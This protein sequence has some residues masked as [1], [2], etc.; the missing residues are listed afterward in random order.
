MNGCCRWWRRSRDKGQKP[1]ELAASVP[2]DW[3]QRQ[4]RA[5]WAFPALLWRHDWWLAAFCAHPCGYRDFLLAPSTLNLQHESKQWD[6][7]TLHVQKSCTVW[8]GAIWWDIRALYLFSKTFYTERMVYWLK[9][10]C[11][12][13]SRSF[14]FAVLNGIFYC[15]I[16]LDWKINQNLHIWKLNEKTCFSAVSEISYRCAHINTHRVNTTSS[17]S[18]PEFCSYAESLL[19]HSKKASLT[20]LQR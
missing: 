13:R 7:Y 2:W 18:T 15:L 17:Y 1:T 8:N 14:A 3:R 19:T 12:I 6:I 10:Q 20:P 5:K 16:W 11:F 9:P 4:P